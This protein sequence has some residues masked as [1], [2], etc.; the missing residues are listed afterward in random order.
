[1]QEEFRFHVHPYFLRLTLP[2]SVEDDEDASATYNVDT[3]MVVVR[4]RKTVPGTHFEG[5]DM[6]TR[7]LTGAKS[8]KKRVSAPLIE[9]LGSTRVTEDL[10][11]VYGELLF[12]AS[13]FQLMCR[14]RG[15]G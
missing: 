3:G 12:G 8:D 4:L 13:T 15:L 10:A 9:V 5:L 7:L 2:G 1:M 14:S 6:I 11:T